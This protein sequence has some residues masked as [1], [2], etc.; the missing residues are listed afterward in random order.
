MKPTEAILD[1]LANPVLAGLHAM[2]TELTPAGLEQA[3]HRLGFA[4]AH[5]D[6]AHCTGKADFLERMATALALPGWFGHN[7]DAFADCLND[8]SWLDAP[9]HVIVL[10]HVDDFRLRDPEGFAIAIEILG[11]AAAAWAADGV[12]MWIF[13]DSE[14]PSA[15]DPASPPA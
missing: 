11:E 3:A 12:S 13:F 2:G 4:F 9:G 14:T 10:T 5:A 15:H 7:W 1:R 8:L 6:L